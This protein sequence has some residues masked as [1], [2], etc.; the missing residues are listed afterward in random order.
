MTEAV[1]GS[2]VY[3]F[4]ADTANLKAGLAEARAQLRQMA[5]QAQQSSREMQRGMEETNQ[6]IQ[7]MSLSARLFAS[8][9]RGALVGVISGSFLREVNDAVEKVRQLE[10]ASRALGVE[11]KALKS[12][13]KSA[14]FFGID[15]AQMNKEL[16]HLAEQLREASVAGG[17]LAD[18]LQKNGI[19]LKDA[20]G[21][22]RPFQKVL[23]DIANLIRDADNEVDKLNALKLLGLSEEMARVFERGSEAV[24]KFSASAT[25]AGE[26]TNNE[27]VRKW[28]YLQDAWSKVWENI[29]DKT[30]DVMYAVLAAIG[31]ALH[32]M[33]LQFGELTREIE[34][35]YAEL[36]RTIGTG[37]EGAGVGS[38]GA[39]ESRYQASM[40]DIAKRSLNARLLEREREDAM[41]DRDAGLGRAP[42]TVSRKGKRIL[43]LYDKDK[44]KNETSSDPI[45]SYI[46]SLKKAQEVAK[47]EA[48]NW[49]RSNIQRAQAVALARAQAIADKEGVTLTDA[50]RQQILSLGGAT[51]QYKDR[52]EELRRKQQDLNASMREFADT[53]TNS[54]SELITRGKSA[55][56]VLADLARTLANSVLRGALTGEGMFGKALGLGGQNSQVGGLFGQLFSGLNFGGSNFAGQAAGAVGPFQ[57]TN[58]FS[59]IGDLF[60]GFF[61]DGGTIPAGQWGIAGERGP[62]IIT[63]PATVTPAGVAQGRSETSNSN[64]F[65][66]HFP[67]GTDAMSFARSESQI[68]AMLVRAAARGQR[69]I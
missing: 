32:K 21:N 42:L 52:V 56:E 61:A 30:I 22:A 11:T 5:D 1:V 18:F 43:G 50:Q 55:K 10:E 7:K 53:V 68:S 59:S 31:D 16:V 57:Q 49:G 39:A 26:R 69:N 25:Q 29:R 9:L 41:A 20:A 17:K 36:R 63:G 33:G 24:E 27:L 48:D 54:L 47:A 46:D 19:A 58:F 64:T 6:S 37:L 38:P 66:F 44:D 60:S 67:P 13:D 12:L 65:H 45:E 35:R 8:T 4:K 15:P 51:Q 2:L 40:L 3:Q 34:R 28:E 14:S 62:E 23:A